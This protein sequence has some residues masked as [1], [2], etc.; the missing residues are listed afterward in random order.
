MCKGVKLHFEVAELYY[1]SDPWPERSPVKSGYENRDNLQRVGV[2]T[3]VRTSPRPFTRHYGLPRADPQA[4]T[5]TKSLDEKSRPQAVYSLQDARS[6]LEMPKPDSQPEITSDSGREFT[7]DKL[8]TSKKA[9]VSDPGKRPSHISDSSLPDG[10]RK[11]DVQKEIDYTSPLVLPPSVN[12]FNADKISRKSETGKNQTNRENPHSK[13]RSQSMKDAAKSDGSGQSIGADLVPTSITFAKGDRVKFHEEGGQKGIQSSV[14]EKRKLTASKAVIPALP[15]AQ[16]MAPKI[17]AGS[18]ASTIQAS[19][20]AAESVTSSRDKLAADDA[21]TAGIHSEASRGMTVSSWPKVNCKLDEDVASC[22]LAEF[23]ASRKESDSEPDAV[24]SVDK[25]KSAV[26]LCDQNVLPATDK[27]EWHRNH[28]DD[29]IGRK[30]DIIEEA[31]SESNPEGRID[32]LQRPQTANNSKQAKHKTSKS[33]SES[34]LARYQQSKPDQVH[35]NQLLPGRLQPKLEDVR[36]QPSESQ[37]VQP[38]PSESPPDTLELEQAA[39]DQPQKE[40]RMSPDNDST[41]VSPR[42]P[43]GIWSEG[44]FSS[45]GKP[46][47]SKQTIPMR[48]ITKAVLIGMDLTDWQKEYQQVMGLVKTATGPAK[49]A[50]TQ[51]TE[52]LRKGLVDAEALLAEL[53]SKVSNKKTA[54]KAAMK[55]VR[56]AV[57]SHKRNAEELSLLYGRL[58]RD[59]EEK[60]DKAKAYP[61]L[62]ESD[63]RYRGVSA[64]RQASSDH[65]TLS[66]R[67]APSLQQTSSN[68]SDSSN[69]ME[70]PLRRGQLY[71]VESSSGP[72]RPGDVFAS[73]TA[74]QDTPSIDSILDQAVAVRG[75][76][77]QK[78]T[79]QHEP[80]QSDGPDDQGTVVILVVPN[81]GDYFESCQ[82]DTPAGNPRPAVDRGLNNYGQRSPFDYILNRKWSHGLSSETEPQPVQITGVKG[83]EHGMQ[84]GLHQNGQRNSLEHLSHPRPWSELGSPNQSGSA[85]IS[86][87]GGP[88]DNMEGGEESHERQVSIDGVIDPRPGPFSDI[89]RPASPPARSPAPPRLEAS[90]A[91]AVQANMQAPTGSENMQGRPTSPSTRTSS[92]LSVRPTSPTY[93]GVARPSS[94][95]YADIAKSKGLANGAEMERRT[96]NASNGSNAPLARRPS[97]SRGKMSSVTNPSGAGH[98][99]ARAMSPGSR[100]GSA[101]DRTMSPEGRNEENR[102]SDDWKVGPEGEWGRNGLRLRGVPPAKGG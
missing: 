93:A 50:W 26:E 77:S 69:R 86:T 12:E 36:P 48:E 55:K 75:E 96:S 78:L 3:N 18:D 52:N 32:R 16:K 27:C 61:A 5:T 68:C 17:S 1:T 20:S 73:D 71:N 8:V 62:H 25:D 46:A 66:Q 85:N 67:Q 19:I 82:V 92:L 79:V 39:V 41:R 57:E 101:G 72:A 33:S 54:K 87:F 42:V 35:A 37:P 64:R 94:P 58:L 49:A 7:A 70:H 60:S 40:A 22:V 4:R 80:G 23:D 24:V 83:T 9:S 13:Q 44:A 56:T 2:Y 31:A 65:N 34:L 99:K 76:A 100:A 45:Q 97:N 74:D 11:L 21:A 29:M 102:G 81:V 47:N 90:I 43:G 28:A 51:E 14:D 88:H 59:A 53:E 38:H 63:A 91:P 84:H 6:C 89:V 10:D 95:T 30:P 15:K 98:G